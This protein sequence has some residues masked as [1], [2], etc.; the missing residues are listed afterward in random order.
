MKT[1]TTVA[2]VVLSILLAVS[3]LGCVA[4]SKLITPADI[5]PGPVR[6]AEKGGTAEPNEYAGWPSLAKAER[7][8]K[9]VDAAHN[10]IQLQLKQEIETDILDYSIHKDVVATAVEKAQALENTLFGPEGLLS[11]GLT[12]MGVGGMGG[13]LGLMRRRPGD[14]SPEDVD[15]ALQDAGLEGKIKGAQIVEIVKGIESFKSMLPEG[16][17]EAGKGKIAEK[18]S[19]GT[20]EAVAVAKANL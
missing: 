5:D 12:A 11:I 20:K 3:G 18:M 15:S 13:L 19:D 6:Y 17:W 9:D 2:I 4:L 7:L 1:R 8:A 10:T 14:W 16:V